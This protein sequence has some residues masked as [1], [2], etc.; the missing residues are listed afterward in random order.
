MEVRQTLFDPRRAGSIWPRFLWCI[1]IGLT[2]VGPRS[3][4]LWAGEREGG[5]EEGRSASD[6]VLAEFEFGKN[7]DL[8]LVPVR[9][10]DGQTYQ[11]L[12]DTGTSGMFV[13][14]ALQEY[15]RATGRK[16]RV[17]G[18]GQRT[19]FSLDEAWVGRLPLRSRICVCGDLLA[20]RELSGY[21][22]R[23]FIGME[24]LRE[25][26]VQVD[27]DGGRIRFL[28]HTGDAPGKKVPLSY[29]PSGCPVVEARLGPKF[30]EKFVIDTGFGGPFCAC[31]VR[32]ADFDAL[33][34]QRD[35]RPNPVVDAIQTPFGP[36]P[37]RIGSAGPLELAGFIHDNVFVQEADHASIGLECLSRY[38]LTF[39]FPNEVM[40]VE[41]GGRFAEP[42]TTGLSGLTLRRKD[43]ATVVDTVVKGRAAAIAG[44]ES[45]DVLIQLDGRDINEFR[46]HELSRILCERGR[47]FR[48]LIQRRGTQRE[49]R[50]R[51]DAALERMR[52]P[53]S[54]GRP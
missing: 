27:F 11:F 52:Q 42:R 29:E 7:G 54:A 40:C 36:R 1:A 38:R 26:V 44:L 19:L 14:V 50:L 45:G 13:D 12:L 18:A 47:T 30:V 2:L 34:A 49:C 32:P 37:R 3:L 10:A 17:T 46:M 21:D 53:R 28:R 15:L 23:G 43:G 39:D 22:I 6:N 4:A 35:I 25:Y 24:F 33:L 20:M 31:A 9:F 41:E 5:Q 48:L 16:A 51:P 8:I